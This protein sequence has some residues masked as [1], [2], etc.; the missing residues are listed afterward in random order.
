MS[1]I[2][3]VMKRS[4]EAADARRYPESGRPELLRS[5]KSLKEIGDA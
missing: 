5:G 2:V 3:A 4:D 1:G